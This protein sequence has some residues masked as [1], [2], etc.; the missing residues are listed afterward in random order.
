MEVGGK[1]II[2]KSHYSITPTCSKLMA[3]KEE[4]S[5]SDCEILRLQGYNDGL[6]MK[7]TEKVCHTCCSCLDLVAWHPTSPL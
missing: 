1:A 2:S 4:M 5:I 3:L 6:K 7:M